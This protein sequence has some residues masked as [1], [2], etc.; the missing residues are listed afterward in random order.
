MSNIKA[1]IF[2]MDGVI[3]DSEI[4]YQQRRQNFLKELGYELSLQWTD[5]IGET[6]ESLWN[7]IEDQIDLP[8]AELERKYV[9]YK[10]AHQIQ[11]E[12]LL[13]P[14]IKPMIQWLN[15]SGYKV[16]LASSSTMADIKRCLETHDLMPYFDVIE[17]AR[18]LG[19]PKPS[20]LVYNVTK[21]KLGCADDEIL[22][23]EDSK[24]GIHSAKEA[25]L[26]VA[27]YQHPKYQ[28][29]QAKADYQIVQYSQI[30]S[31]LN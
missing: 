22:V 17:S 6:F 31:L 14:G 7:Q 29:D 13:M 21:E 20:P 18:D 15:V 2:D 4:W 8:L 25:G 28:L 1:V 3:V 27:A 16:A 10:K 26:K 9:A 19:E 24:A 5:F 23:I 11:Y 12:E 30:V